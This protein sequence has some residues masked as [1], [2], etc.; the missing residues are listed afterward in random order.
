MD[1]QGVAVDM[2]TSLQNAQLAHI[3]TAPTR[4]YPQGLRLRPDAHRLP[5]SHLKLNS[6]KPNTKTVNR[7]NAVQLQMKTGTA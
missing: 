3:P 5:N 7:G 4:A 2:W 6:G 1:K